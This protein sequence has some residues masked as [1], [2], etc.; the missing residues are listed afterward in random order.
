[1]SRPACARSRSTSPRATSTRRC[2]RSASRRT[3]RPI[4]SRSTARCATSTRRRTCISC[5]WAGWRLSARRRRCSS[6]SK[7]GRVETHPIAGTRPRGANEEDDLRLGEELKRN[8]KERAEHVM[9]VDLGRNDL[10]RVCEFGSVR[11]PQYMALERYSHVMHL[12]STVDGRLA[13]DRDHLDALVA[14]FPAGT[15]SGAP[16]IRAMQILVGARADPPR[17]LRRGGRLHRLR[18][19]PRFLH[20]DPHDHD[21]Q[22]PR[23][24]P[25]RR[26][27]SSP[28]RTRRRSTRRRATRPGRCCRRSRWRR[29]A[30]R[31]S[32]HR[33]LRFVHLQPRP[34]PRRAGRAAAGEAQRRD[35]ARR[36]RGAEARRGSSSRPG[37]G[38][39]EDAGI[40]VDVIQRFGPHDCRCSASASATRASASPSAARSSARR[41]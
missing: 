35:H 1:M 41:S 34:V 25:G 36:D 14:C 20:R 10:G 18:R 7:G 15:V 4:R 16:K 39:P 38:R 23:A 27:A 17:H 28:T 37:P 2:C 29:Q 9:L 6:A 24:R 5:G 30:S 3:S 22:R 32:P 13:E 19:Q 33:Q 12:V 26:R 11:V 40:T 8:E 31:D 21:P